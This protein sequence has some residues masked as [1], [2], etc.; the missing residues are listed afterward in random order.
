MRG[1]SLRFR[2]SVWYAAVLT[3][4]LLGYGGLMYFGLSS[5]LHRGLQ[6]L[7]SRQCQ[8]I[9]GRLA[10]DSEI[11]NPAA[12]LHQIGR[13][14]ELN[15]LFVRVSSSAGVVLYRSS[16]IP[17]D[18]SFDPNR[19][20]PLLQEPRQE[21]LRTI[22]GAGRSDLLI[23]ALPVHLPGGGN[24]IVEVGSDMDNISS[25]L[26]TFGIILMLGIPVVVLTAIGGA[27]LISRNTMK[28]LDTIAEQAE[29]FTSRNFGESLPVLHTG[30]ELERLTVALNRMV[31]RLEEAF[32]HIERFSADVSHELR[33]PLAILRGELEL[34]QRSKGLP[35]TIVEQIGSSLEEIERLSRIV[36]QLLEISRLEAAPMQK[37]EAPIDL[38]KLAE[39]TSEQ[40]RLLADVK[41]VALNYQITAGCFV[42]GSAG[43]LTQVVANL[44]DNA[45]KY[46]NE[47]GSVDVIVAR[48]ADRVRLEVRD[49]G[50]GIPQADIPRI[51]DR[52]YR[53]DP[54]RSH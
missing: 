41:S 23:D 22:T 29:R 3:V 14:L 25:V 48:V 8:L 6:R 20:P 54:A 45:I 9:A 11:S 39:S 27:I 5:Y 31:R 17:R 1:F 30:D 33:T 52:F 43:L 38:G 18:H 16:F 35:D 34:V 2:M 24:L 37:D 50:I 47:A 46:T 40:M 36:S 7:L 44:L 15:G 49:N 42:E 21:Y 26:H 19:V 28:P 4:C 53:A 12:T 10:A 51:F 32:Q 13:D